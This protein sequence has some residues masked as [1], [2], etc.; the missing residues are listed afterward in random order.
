LPENAC[1]DGWFGLGCFRTDFWV[2]D[3]VTGFLGGSDEELAHYTAVLAYDEDLRM[4]IAKAARGRL[5]TE[6]ANP[7]AIWAGW[8]QLF[9]SLDES[10]RCAA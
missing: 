2:L 8:N 1:E 10:R 5:V 6:L 4:G 3:G 9:D 7:A